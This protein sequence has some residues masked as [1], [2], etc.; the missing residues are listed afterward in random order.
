MSSISPTQQHPSRLQMT[1]LVLGTDD[2]QQ[3]VYTV[4]QVIESSSFPDLRLNI[5]SIL[6]V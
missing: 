6:R 5:A 4:D 3:R 2:Y 1:V